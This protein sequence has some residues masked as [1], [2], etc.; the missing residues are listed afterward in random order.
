MLSMLYAKI[1]NSRFVQ[2][3]MPNKIVYSKPLPFSTVLRVLKCLK[4]V[5]DWSKISFFT[6]S[7]TFRM[8]FFYNRTELH[9]TL[10]SKTRFLNKLRFQVS[11]LKKRNATQKQTFNA[12][13]YFHLNSNSVTSLELTFCS[14]TTGRNNEFC[15]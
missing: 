7:D 4:D 9:L 8:Y 12:N 14:K 2:Y 6:T 3:E 13:Y 1:P 15:W 5:V 11:K 10:L